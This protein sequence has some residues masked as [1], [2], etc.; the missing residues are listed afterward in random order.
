MA[1]SRNEIVE[2]LIADLK[3]VRP[4]RL[5]RALGLLLVIEAAVL[6]AAVAYFGVRA[7]L[8]VRILDPRS[9]ALAAALLVAAAGSAWAALRLSIPGRDISPAASGTL[10]V[11][12][13]LAAVATTTLLPWGGDWTGLGPVLQT[14]WKCIAST[15]STALIPWVVAVAAVSRLAP[16]RPLRAA[17]FV[18]LSAFALGALATEIHCS[19]KD[20]YHLAIGH[21]L[22]VLGLAAATA[23]LSAWL[24]GEG[25]G[26]N[27]D[28]INGGTDE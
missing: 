24:L 18:G 26:A 4:F 5:R 9:V 11:L 3:P 1:E 8:G 10:L 19:Q 12:P 27:M 25:R 14:C 17:L 22:P 16:L 7:D 2:T 15:T 23:L 20:A 21:Y 13:A 28:S 6:L